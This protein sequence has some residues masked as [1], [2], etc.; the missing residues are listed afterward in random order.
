MP[1]PFEEISSEVRRLTVRSF[2]LACAYARGGDLRR[3][4]PEAEAVDAEL[5]TLLPR[6]PAH[7]RVRCEVARAVLSHLLAPEG[8]H[9]RP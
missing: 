7:M 2:D 3:L 4:G 9:H 6:C 8:T 5:R 1:V